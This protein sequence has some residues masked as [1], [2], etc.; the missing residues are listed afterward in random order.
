MELQTQSVGR[1]LTSVRWLPPRAGQAFTDT[2]LYFVTGTGAHHQE[3]NLWT[4]PNPDFETRLD[5][6]ANEPQ[7][8]ATLAARCPH[9]GDVAD[10]QAVSA[11]LI[12]VG[13]SSGQISLFD[14]GHTV[15]GD[16]D[17]G[18]E[19]R[20]RDSAKLGSSTALSVNGE[21]EIVSSGEDGSLAYVSVSRMDKAETHQVDGA[22]IT[23]VCWTT[24]TQLAASNRAGQIKLY[25]RRTEPQRASSVLTDANSSGFESIDVHP[26]Q[27]FRLATG[28]SQG[29]VLVWDVRNTKEPIVESRGVHEGPVWEVQY[30]GDNIVSCSDDASLAVT[31]WEDMEEIRRLSSFFNRLSVNCF[32]ICQSTSTGLLVAGTDSGNMLVYKN[33]PK[34]L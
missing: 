21:R 25:D 1:K 23:D 32:D 4:A 14:I 5:D 31:R 16:M 3:L 19:I 28:T 29:G 24:P 7:D 10:I 2:D 18:S 20:L 15:E 8:L 22:S 26:S 13:S 34:V 33:L 9:S 30:W 27:T 6:H 12:A 11:D 17:H